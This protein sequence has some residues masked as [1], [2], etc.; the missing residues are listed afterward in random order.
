MQGYKLGRRPDYSMGCA[1]SHHALE[2][3]VPLTG[4]V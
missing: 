2:P 4:C 3:G 1:V